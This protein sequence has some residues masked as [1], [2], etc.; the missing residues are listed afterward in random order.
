MHGRVRRRKADIGHI[1]STIARRDLQAAAESDRQMCVV[2]T[3][4]VALYVCFRRGS[5]GAGV[6]VAEGDVVVYEVADGLH[7][8]PAER[9]MSEEAPSLIGQAIGLTVAAAEQEQQGFRRQV[10]DLLLQR[11][12]VDRIGHPRI[13]NNG[14]SAEGETARRCGEAAE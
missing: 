10:L 2:A 13:T 14:V 7:P 3:N 9:R 12:Q 6:L 1:T 8:R 5:G 11:V 4:T